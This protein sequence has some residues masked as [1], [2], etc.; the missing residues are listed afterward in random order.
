[1]KEFSLM[2]TPRNLTFQNFTQ[3]TNSK[4]EFLFYYTIS[5]IILVAFGVFIIIFINYLKGGFFRYE[6]SISY[7]EIL[8]TVLPTIILCS[9]A[10]P[11]IRI[12]YNHEQEISPTMSVKCT[13]HQWY[14][15]YEYTD[16]EDLEF[17]SF[18]TPTE[19]INLGD[20]RYL[21]ADNRLILP[22]R[23]N[24]RFLISREDV[25]HSLTIPS[26]G[27]KIDATPGRLNRTNINL[28]HVGVFFGQCRELCGANHS[29]IPIV[30]ETCPNSLFKEWVLAFD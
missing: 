1:M 25:I 9:I 5:Q 6:K 12:L 29:F 11:R 21:E 22:R 28:D 26:L 30:I 2:I 27:L 23:R 4:I 7:H 15:S 16:F 19:D 3:L 24:I 18:M 8:W 17:D 13:G 14:W 10:I 20:P